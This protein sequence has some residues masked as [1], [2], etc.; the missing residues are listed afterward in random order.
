MRT[1][2]RVLAVALVGLSTQ[3]LADPNDFIIR[4]LGN[5]ADPST[6]AAANAR[7]AAFAKEVGAALTSTNLMAPGTLGHAGFNVSA[8]LTTAFLRGS[9][10]APSANSDFFQMPTERDYPGGS[11]LL[12]PSVHV[13]KGLPF[14]F[15][16]G[17]RLAWIDRSNMFA[18]TGEV[19]WAVNEGF[20]YLPDINVR[21]YGMRLFNTRDFD[22][23]ALGLDLGIGKRFAIGGQVTLAPYAGW[24][25]VWVGAGSGQV[26][27]NPGRTYA[28]SVNPPN[29]QLTQDVGMF[30]EVSLG[31]AP[32]NRFYGGL[33]FVGGV[34]QI[35]AEIS[36]SLLG[37][38]GEGTASLKPPPV[39]TL[40]TTLGLD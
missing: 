35:G 9:R 12:I 15:E 24:N 6:G 16:L 13:R 34:I 11:P 18:A 26:D 21:G 17:T 14:S 30:K 27:F 20:A 2:T 25:L 3:A 4:N 32:H 33:R 10:E 7:F 38:V 40:N 29:A 36:Y 28:E 37:S 23:G 22:L 39:L 8:E 5:P 31:S 19:R 1:W